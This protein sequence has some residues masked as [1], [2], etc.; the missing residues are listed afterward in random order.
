MVVFRVL[1]VFLFVALILSTAHPAYPQENDLQKAKAPHQ[2]LIKLYERGPYQEA[3]KIAENNL[4]IR[5]KALE[6]VD[7]NVATSLHNQ[8]EIYR[9]S[10]DYAK[11]EP[12][13]KRSLAIYEKALG[14]DH[15][16]VAN[17]LNSLATLYFAIGDYIKAKPLFKRSLAI[18]EK[19]LGPDHLHVATSLSNLG[20]VYMKLGYY[21]EAEPLI[22]RSLAIYEKAFGPDKPDVANSLNSLATLYLATGDFIKAEPL[23]MRSLAIREEAL[24]PVDPN[25]ATSLHNLGTVYWKLGDYAKAEPLFK[26]SL[27][28]YEKAFGPDHPHVALSLNNLALLYYSLGDYAKAEPLFK[29][30]LAIHEKALGPDHPHVALNLLNLGEVYRKLGDYAKAEPLFKR[31]LAIYEKA[32]GPDHPDVANSLS[33]LAECSRELGDYAKAEPLFKRS[34][35]IQEKALGPDHPHVANSLNNLAGLYQSLGDYVKAEPL[36]NQSLAIYEKALGPDHPHVA[37]SLNNLSALYAALDDFELALEFQKRAQKIDSRLI[38]QVMGFTSED[39]KTKFLAMKMRGLDAYLSLISQRLSKSPINRKDALDLWLKRKGVILEAQRRFQE[40]L[41]YS[42]DLEAV[43]TF[44]ELG[45]VRAKLS[46]FAFGSSRK[47]GRDVYEKRIADLEVQKQS[48]EAKLS[49]LSQVFALKQKISD[50]NSES[51]AEKLPKNSALIE[52]A[53]VGMWNFKAKGK[54]NKW[55]PA[56]YLAFVL[57]AGEADKVSMIDLGEAE[58]IDMAVGKFKKKEG[59]LN[60]TKG[61]KVREAF[62]NI[63]DMVFEPIKNELGDVKDIFISPD[64]NLNLIPFEVLQ[65]PNGRYLIEDYTFNYL[66]AGRDL[67]GFEEIEEKGQR[68]LLIGDPDFDMGREEKSSTLRRLAL[69]DDKQKK[70]IKRSV[71]MRGFHFSNLPGTKEEVRAI[72]DIIGKDNADLYTGKEALEEVLRAKGSPK[73]LHL[74]THGFFLKDLD[75]SDLMDETSGR[76]IQQVVPMGKKIKMDDPLLRSGIA[77]AG[78]NNTLKLE[79][80]EKSDGIVTAEKILGLRLRG[81]DMVVLS[82]CETG[83]GEV[84]T[85]E[86]VFGLRR[87]FTQAGAKSLVM[88]MWAVPDKETKELM[89][90]FYKN[91]QSDKMNRAQALRK[92]ALKEMKIV[93]E[94]YDTTNPFYWGAFVFL[95]EP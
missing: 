57:H 38:D 35:V 28:I 78:A 37:N 73:I 44:Q 48:L 45:F 21:A 11:A 52:F 76:G 15:L 83:V 14:P 16:D 7:P 25:V 79:E 12:L 18:R 54:E 93:K 19:T 17:S 88:S 68:A 80:S 50:A 81:T 66:A 74:A 90:D 36:Y 2:Q 27:A 53:V 77:L 41:V 61:T 23:F 82:A 4:T 56:H 29:R 6:P 26:R 84:K 34:L 55:N 70:D 20:E 33:S 43:K 63:Y 1:S 64:G 59:E 13:F 49:R 42:D 67:L 32:L 30:S 60:D 51:V 9:K 69:G 85:G 89:I 31:S 92:A 24:G 72:Q 58:K 39:Q 71:D 94:R 65:G 47:E 22:K 5:E 95:G 46:K 75:F 62:R 3:I 10:G 8:G 40:A 87:A 86:G 91:I